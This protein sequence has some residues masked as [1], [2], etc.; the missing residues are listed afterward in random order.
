MGS[1]VS[2]KDG[3]RD[4]DG[5]SVGNVVGATDPV[6]DADVD[7]GSDGIGNSSTQKKVCKKNDKKGKV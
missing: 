4:T 7:G 1:L 5:S 2:P 3:A 6:G